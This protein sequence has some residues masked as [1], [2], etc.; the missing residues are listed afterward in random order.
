MQNENTDILGQELTAEQGSGSSIKLSE[1]QHFAI[2]AG[3]TVADMKKFDSE[4]TEPKVQIIFQAHGDAHVDED[5]DEE[6]EHIVRY[7]KSRPYKVST[8]EKSGLMKDLMS[9]SKSSSPKEVIEKMAENGKFNLKVLLGKV[10]LLTITHDDKGYET[11]SLI[12]LPKKSQLQ[13]LDETAVV[14]EFMQNPKN[15]RQSLFLEG[16]KLTQE[17]E[18]KKPLLPE[19]VDIDFDE[20]AVF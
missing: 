2:V 13:D 7:I 3:L 11:I 9:W 8:H 16:V 1:G 6:G 14:P 18:A 20:E 10:A 5:S 12:G 19:E 4:E 17:E 15:L